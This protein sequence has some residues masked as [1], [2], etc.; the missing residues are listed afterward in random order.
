MACGSSLVVYM[1]VHIGFIVLVGGLQPITPPPVFLSPV[2]WTLWFTLAL[3]IVY[4]G[5]FYSL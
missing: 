4:R 3:W 2:V 5:F 1:K